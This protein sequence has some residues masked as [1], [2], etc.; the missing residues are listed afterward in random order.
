M[1][2]GHAIGEIGLGIEPVEL[3]GLKDGIEDRGP[4]AALVRPQK[5]KIL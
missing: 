3:C 1:A 2:L 4:L 5:Q